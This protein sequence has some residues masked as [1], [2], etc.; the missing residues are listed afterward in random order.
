MTRPTPRDTLSVKLGYKNAA[1]MYHTIGAAVHAKDGE[2]I[3]RTVRELKHAII[4]Y[5]VPCR[6]ALHRLLVDY[7]M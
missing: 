2:A 3:R 6:D 1:E 7:R 4:P 5:L